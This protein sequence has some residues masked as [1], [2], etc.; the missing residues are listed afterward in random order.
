MY[1]VTFYSFK[2]GVGRTLALAN[3]GV[4][5]AR[6]GRRVLLVDFD[7]EAPGLHTFKLLKPKEATPGIVNYI[8]DYANTLSSPDVRSYIYEAFDVGQQD[9]RLWVMPSGQ[10]DP[11]YARKL[12]GINWQHLYDKQQGYLMFEDMKAQWEKVYHPDYVL[13]DS[14][15]GH[16]DIGGI[17]TRQLPNA[18]VVLFFPNEQ[19]LNGLK[20]IV[21]AIRAEDKKTEKNTQMHFVMSNVPDLDDEEEIIAGMGKKFRED[22]GYKELTSIIYRYDSLSLLQ[23]SIFVAERPKSRLAKEYN[24]LTQEITEFNIEDREGVIQSIKKMRMHFIMDEQSKEDNQE[25]RIE[26]II[27]HHSKDGELLYLIAKEFIRWDGGVSK[28][29]DMLISRSIECGFRSPDAFLIKA[30]IL[31]KEGDTQ[32]AIKLIGEAFNNSD[33]E[34]KDLSLGINIIRRINPDKLIETCRSRAFK[35]LSAVKVIRLISELQ[36]CKP[37]LQ[38]SVELLQPYHNDQQLKVATVRQ[39]RNLL[40]L[41]LIGLGDFQ[42]AITILSKEVL[43]AN[44]QDIEDVFNYAMAQ[45]GLKREVS[46]DLFV[47]VVKLYDPDREPDSNYYQCLAI[48]FWAVDNKEEALKYL[49]LSS[50]LISDEIEQFSCWR[51]LIVSSDE[52]YQ[53]CHQIKRLIEGED[54]KP[55]F[56]NQ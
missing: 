15:T 53:D 17:C 36:W 5:L 6:T 33:V 30:D 19:N 43:L 24:K 7:L 41:S 22:L 40:A 16:T 10:N 11:E 35:S 47:N 37:G 55:L 20:P 8:T 28:K 14:R 3:V 39:I 52:F 12:A 9:G 54:V 27:K 44:K 56:W 26:K 4:Q 51:Y 13:I 50:G 42:E 18:V 38:V 21:S 1:V 45:W 31:Q 23:Q 46:K 25:N 2:G 29:S 49:E 32:E 48:A 34:L